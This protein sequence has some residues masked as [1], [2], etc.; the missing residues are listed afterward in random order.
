MLSSLAA[1][2]FLSL[3]AFAVPLGTASCDKLPSWTIKDLSIKSRDEVGSSGSASFTLGYDLTGKTD[4]L[5]CTL[6]A[7][8]RCEIDGTPSDK[9]IILNL[10]T[11]MQ[12][13]YI[14]ISQ[15]ITCDGKT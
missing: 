6:V 10:Q 1:F 13:V 5:S 4:K 12:Q 7:N 2:A 11:Q 3:T 14:S 8:Y 9:S 15:S